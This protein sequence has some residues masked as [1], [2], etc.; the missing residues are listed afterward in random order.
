VLAWFLSEALNR[1]KVA[2]LYLRGPDEPGADDYFQER[3]ELIEEVARASVGR[4]FRMRLARVARLISCLA[5]LRP[6]WVSD[7]A[8]I[9]FKERADS[10]TRD[11]QPDI[12][13]AE[14]HVMGQYLPALDG[15]AAPRVLVEHEPGVRAAPYLTT[16][17]PILA[18]AV[19]RIEKRSWR[20]YEATLYQQVNGIV[21]FTESDRSAVQELAGHTL[22]RVIPPRFA[23]PD[24]PLD[25]LGKLPPSLVFVGNFIHPP[26][27]DAAVWLIRSIFPALQSQVP[28]LELF[29]VGDQPPAQ[30]KQLAREK[31]VITGRVPDVA[32]Y[33]ERAS[34]CV[35][36]MRLGGGMRIKVLEALAAGKAVVATP[37]AV[38]GLGLQD[39]RQVSLAESEAG[40]VK[41]IMRLLANPDERVSLGGAARAW[42]CEHFGVDHSIG[43]YEAFYAELLENSRQPGKSRG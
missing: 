27:V 9:R 25:P 26:N 11:F 19:N 17:P 40:L 15:G 29:I 24:M 5:Q 21:V 22:I 35:A 32:H 31:I 4:S 30:L 13:Q 18:A 20:R 38:E 7:W 2:I 12:V 37:L 10:L 41:R 28:E 23:I 8:S 14:Y 3:C 16:L 42:A 34:L 33:L 39:G 36:P 43:G 1:H 6:F